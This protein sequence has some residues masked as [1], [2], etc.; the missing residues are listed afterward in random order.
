MMIFV[1]SAISV[2]LLAVVCYGAFK[3]ASS[4]DGPGDRLPFLLLGTTALSLASGCITG[5]MSADILMVE[6]MPALVGMNVLVSSLWEKDRISQLM[7]VFLIFSALPVPLNILAAV[8]WMGILSSP[9]LLTVFCICILLYVSLFIVG[10]AV[11]LR[12]VKVILKTGTLWTSIGIAVDAVYA[13]MLMTV[14]LLYVAVSAFSQ[15]MEEG[16]LAVFPLLNGG[17]LA[18]LGIRKADDVM[19]V[20]WR[21][22]ERRIVESMKV[23]KVETASDPSSIDDVYREI[24]ERV[25]AYFDAEKPF[26][27]NE[28]TINDLVKVLYSNKLYISRAISQFTGRN[29]CQFVNYHR[30]VYSMEMFRKNPDMKIHE[31]AVGCGF[32]TDVSYNMA[33]RLFMG[34]TPGEW[35]RKER[36]R[37][38]KMKK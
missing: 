24:Y 22:Q 27:D 7:P 10:M 34:E 25:V 30:V 29:F 1:T 33:F 12:N 13:V 37:R 26:L 3:G 18:A 38:L 16:W 5:D 8:G 28:L 2:L 32:N 20:F 23:N 17:M 4:P 9:V 21:R 15:G 36:S 31:L 6:M 14:S 11:R 19:F 35:C